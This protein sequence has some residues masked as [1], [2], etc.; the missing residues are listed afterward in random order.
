MVQKQKTLNSAAQIVAEIGALKKTMPQGVINKR[1]SNS[2]VWE[3]EI[4]P[5]PLSLLYRIKIEYSYGKT[6]QVFVTSPCPLKKFPGTKVL[7]HTYSTK[8]QKLCLYYPGIGEWNKNK[9]IART[10]L[11]W[12]SEWLQ[13][14]E[15][16]LATGFWLG[17]GLHPKKNEKKKE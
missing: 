10:I 17:E 3:T 16:W 14:Y 2:F 12:A 9:L 4:Q 5:T 7:P 6:P 13:Y 11:P 15:L 8:E 1:S